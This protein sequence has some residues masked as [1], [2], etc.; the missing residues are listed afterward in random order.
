MI[1]WR[2]A[3]LL[4]GVGFAAWAIASGHATVVIPIVCVL[5]VVSLR[6]RIEV[7]ASTVRLIVPLGR[8]RTVGR[9]EIVGIRSGP[10]WFAD[11]EL[12]L[13]GKRFVRLPQ[14]SRMTPLRLQIRP[15]AETL[16]R[17]AALLDVP[18]VD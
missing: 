6:E 7:S 2:V 11:V 9:D 8:T 16:R 1:M 3:A 17:L 5:L 18:V 12:V 15:T 13:N 14:L 4:L 10:R